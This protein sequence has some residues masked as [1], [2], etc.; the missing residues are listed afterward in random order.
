MSFMVGM[1]KP[2][3]LTIIADQVHGW[4][5]DQQINQIEL[6]LLQLVMLPK[7]L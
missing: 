6:L 5:R 4:F 1:L 3:I 2:V 7:Q